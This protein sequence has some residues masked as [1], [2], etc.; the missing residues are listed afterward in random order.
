MNIFI[1]DKCPVTAAKYY[2]DKLCS[3]IS[4]EICQMLATNFSANYLNWG[5]LPKK[6]GNAYKVSYPNHPCTIWMREK[7]ENI[8]WSITHG[9]ALALEHKQRF[10]RLPATYHTLRKAKQLFEQHTGK[11]LNVYVRA[12]NFTRAMP[13]VLKYDKTISTVEAYRVYMH[14]KSYAAWTKSTPKPYWYSL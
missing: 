11:M 12:G 10:G 4:L 1:L 3:K 2:P 6:D 14:S 8:A 7:E 13:D 5:D 9:L